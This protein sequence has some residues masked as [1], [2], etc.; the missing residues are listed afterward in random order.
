MTLWRYALVDQKHLE[1][2]NEIEHQSMLEEY[3]VLYNYDDPSIQYHTITYIGVL[4]KP[5]PE[6]T[7]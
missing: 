3:I 1:D 2:G 6:V 7:P 5:S 4:V